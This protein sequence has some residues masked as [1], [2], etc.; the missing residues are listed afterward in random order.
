MFVSKEINVM[1]TDTQNP[2]FE[3]CKEA[4]KNAD[5]I[6]YNNRYY[7]R[8]M[9]STKDTWFIHAQFVSTFITISRICI[10][11]KT[12]TNCFDFYTKNINLQ[13]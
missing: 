1:K 2:G 6:E 12:T 7:Y 11:L 9:S 5:V 10:N 8:I 13:S 4:A 3:W